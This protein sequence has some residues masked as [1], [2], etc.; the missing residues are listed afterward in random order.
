MTYPH[1]VN[2]YTLRLARM[3]DDGEEI[4]PARIEDEPPTR[5]DPV[6][7]EALAARERGLPHLR[8]VLPT[9]ADLRALLEDSV[10]ALA[11]GE[12]AVTSDGCGRSV[13]RKVGL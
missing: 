4:G 10:S 6:V 13:V 7:A 3:P 12:Y 9:R 8:R 1:L 5:R 2:T 11:R